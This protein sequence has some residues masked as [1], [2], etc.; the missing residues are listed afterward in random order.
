MNGIKSKNGVNFQKIDKE[1]FFKQNLSNLLFFIVSRSGMIDAPGNAYFFMTDGAFF[2]K[3]CSDSFVDEVFSR[4]G[5]RQWNKINLYL[6]DD[7]IIDSKIYKSFV[8]ELCSRNIRDFWFE[9]TF[10]VYKKCFCSLSV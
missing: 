1:S 5:T 2:V 7:L 8:H 9:T 6:C 10:V 4:T 3:N